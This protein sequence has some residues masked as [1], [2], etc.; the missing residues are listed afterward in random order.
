LPKLGWVI[1]WRNRMSRA[2]LFRKACSI[3]ILV[4]VY[5]PFM[6]S[7]AILSIFMGGGPTV[8]STF[9]QGCAFDY[10]SVPMFVLLVFHVLFS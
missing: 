6:L 4:G 9:S 7:V 8:F 2:W 3:A 1:S 10:A 5:I